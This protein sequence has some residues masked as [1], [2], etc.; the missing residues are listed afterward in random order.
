MIIV[1]R[2]A[3]SQG[4]ADSSLFEVMPEHQFVLTE[5]GLDQADD[6]ARHISDKF[7]IERVYS[8]MYPRTRQTAEIICKEIGFTGRIIQDARLRERN[9][10]NMIAKSKISDTMDERKE[11]GKFFF[12]FP[13]PGGDSGL[14]VYDRAASFM[15]RLL[16][17]GGVSEED[18][19]IVTH[20]Y[21]MR[22][23]LMYM[24]GLGV[25]DFEI[26]SDPG[27]ADWAAF[28][29]DVFY[30]ARDRTEKYLK[31]MISDSSYEVFR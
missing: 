24:L 11:F 22:V 9:M 29:W 26:L 23:I 1:I 31:S 12:T 7:E 8:S 15:D 2:H 16:L 4:N 18:V 25:E 27:N 21:T 14:S 3:E 19:L 28:E 13:F 10:G 20:S 17:Y 30:K 6:A 5:R